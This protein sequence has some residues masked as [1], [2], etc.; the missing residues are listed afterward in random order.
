MTFGTTG[1][2]RWRSTTSVIRPAAPATELLR[3]AATCLPGPCQ[4]TTYNHSVLGESLLPAVALELG[5][6]V[7]LL[8]IADA[9]VGDQGPLLGHLEHARDFPRREDRD[10]ANSEAVGARREPERLHGGHSGVVERLG[11]RVSSQAVAVGSRLVDADGK[12]T[13]G[14]LQASKLQLTVEPGTCAR[15]RRQRGIVAAREDVADA[16]AAHGILHEHEPPGLAVA[17][18]GGQAR[19]TEQLAEDGRIDRLAAEA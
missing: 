9:E 10:P 16:L 17:Y 2:R 12:V 11:H 7:R 4:L 19:E 13:R 1:G 8:G 3:W 5:V 6:H 14:L 18:R 15:V